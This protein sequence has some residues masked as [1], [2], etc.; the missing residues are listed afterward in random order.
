MLRYAKAADLPILRSLIRNGALTGSFDQTLATES[1]EASLFF[2]NLRRALTTGY[3]VEEDPDSGDFVAR[4]VPGY[5]YVP[6][7][8]AADHQPIG[9]GLFKAAAVGYE[10]WLAGVEP[11]WRGHGHGRAMIAALLA[12]P[13]GRQ[14]FAVRIKAYGRASEAMA[15][16]LTSMGFACARETPSHSWF[17]RHDAPAEVRAALR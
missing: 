2:A 3:V 14:T 5:V 12:T 11:A 4:A 1:R 7:Q 13:P 10:L 16:L 17:L 6:D 15:H 8:L 9:F